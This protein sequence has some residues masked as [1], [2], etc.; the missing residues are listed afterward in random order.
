MVDI[1]NPLWAGGDNPKVTLIDTTTN[2][3]RVI[4]LYHAQP[5]KAYGN[6]ICSL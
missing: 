5:Q 1:A 2:M 4:S 3:K 6:D